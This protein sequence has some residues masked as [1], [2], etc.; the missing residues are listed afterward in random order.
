VET[1]AVVWRA[2]VRAAPPHEQRRWASGRPSGTV[3]LKVPDEVRV[4]VELEVDEDETELE[5]E[6]TW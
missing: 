2:Q 5:I 4:K 6:L 1:Q 3:A